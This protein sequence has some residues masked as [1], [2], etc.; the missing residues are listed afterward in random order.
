MNISFQEEMQSDLE[1]YSDESIP[2]L[3]PPI[4][5]LSTDLVPKAPNAPT[6]NDNDNLFEV[7]LMRSN[8]IIYII[9]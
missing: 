4:K 3:P 9:L 6:S 8:K 1:I 5:P 2:P 7:T